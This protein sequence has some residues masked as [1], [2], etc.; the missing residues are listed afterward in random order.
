MAQSGYGKLDYKFD[1]MG[2]EIPVAGTGAYGGTGTAGYKLGEFKVTGDLTRND[3]GV[4]SLAKSGGWGRLT[5]SASADGDGCAVGTEVI[6]SPT[7]NGPLAV[8]A[9]V[10]SQ[11]LT[12]RTFWLGFADVNADDVAEP[13]TNSSS[14]VITLTAS[15]LAGFHFDSQLT[16]SDWILVHNGGTTTGV[17]VVADI[18]ADE[19]PVAGESQILRVEIDRD[20]TVRWIINGDLKQTVTNAV[21][22]TVLLAAYVGVWSTTTTAADLDVD[23]LAVEANRDWTV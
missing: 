15:D 6:Y 11:I 10:E 3:C 14:T 4:V 16:D 7:L 21:S 9:R 19:D 13:V 22:P 1:F 8:E 17:T 12:A 2:A 20:G 18:D 5:S 23:Y